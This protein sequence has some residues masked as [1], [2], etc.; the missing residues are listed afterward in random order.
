MTKYSSRRL[1]INFFSISVLNIVVVNNFLLKLSSTG[2]K[3]EELK[4]KKGSGKEKSKDSLVL[5]FYA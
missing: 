4:M 2:I 1:L 3:F 5:T